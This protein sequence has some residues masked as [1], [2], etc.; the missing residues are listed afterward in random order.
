MGDCV[1]VVG[2]T[3]SYIGN[4]VFIQFIFTLLKNIQIRNV[5]SSFC[6][7]IGRA[8]GALAPQ[9][10]RL[11][12]GS[13]TFIPFIIFMLVALVNTIAFFVFIPE[14]KGRRLPEHMPDTAD[15]WCGGGSKKK[16]NHVND[17]EHSELPTSNLLAS[18]E[19]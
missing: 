14:T 5:A 19:L 16:K 8:G 3:V 2:G 9:V 13:W 4:V 17:K 12:S 18:N 11:G 10:L 6:S 1:R 15:W 7:V